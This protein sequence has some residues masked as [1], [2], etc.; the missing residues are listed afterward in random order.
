[1]LVVSVR[2]HIRNKPHSRVLT[3]G[4]VASALVDVGVLADGIRRGEIPVVPILVDA[5]RDVPGGLVP[6]PRRAIAQDVY[7]L[8][9][10]QVLEVNQFDD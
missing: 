1:M 7:T 3:L 5:E 2:S 10:V 6:V 4:W 9:L 8:A